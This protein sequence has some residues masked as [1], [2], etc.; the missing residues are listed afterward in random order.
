MNSPPLSRISIGMNAAVVLLISLL[1]N[2]A[3]VVNLALGFS[4]IEWTAKL[5]PDLEPL[6]PGQL[7]APETLFSDGG[8]QGDQPVS[9]LYPDPGGDVQGLRGLGYARTL[10]V[11]AGTPLVLSYETVLVDPKLN[12]APL[13]VTDGPYS[14]TYAPT[15]PLP[16]SPKRAAVSGRGGTEPIS[17]RFLVYPATNEVLNSRG[18]DTLII[19]PGILGVALEGCIGGPIRRDPAGPPGALTEECMR[20]PITRDVCTGNVGPDSLFPLTVLKCTLRDIPIFD[21]SYRLLA[22]SATDSSRLADADYP[23]TVQQPKTLAHIKVVQRNRMLRRAAGA[24]FDECR[25]PDGA[26]NVVECDQAHL[27]SL[28]RWRMCSGRIPIP[29]GTVANCDPRQLPPNAGFESIGRNWTFSVADPVSGL[30]RENFTAGVTISHIKVRVQPRQQNAIGRYL[31]ADEVTEIRVR[32][33]NV[34]VACRQVVAEAGSGDAVVD[35]QTCDRNLTPLTVAW[36]IGRADIPSS[37]KV[38]QR[39]HGETVGVGR[40]A[41]TGMLRRDF[42]VTDQT[43]ILEFYLQG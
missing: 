2:C 10:W 36:A 17:R 23:G 18:P 39:I 3:P 40:G 31:R 27:L 21:T 29:P 20:T 7:T 28:E 35:P 6:T 38:V 24:P 19:P 22:V 9:G 25:M 42:T 33:G 14:D 13:G 5:R 37:W 34:D 43:V 41:V 32:T 8:A 26:G 30:F 15:V 1:P 4:A 12:N 16:L 11:P